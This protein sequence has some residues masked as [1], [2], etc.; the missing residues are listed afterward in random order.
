MRSQDGSPQRAA[1][2]RTGKNNIGL[3][4]QT[5]RAQGTL[6]PD[7]RLHRVIAGGRHRCSE[8]RLEWFRCDVFA[9]AT[10]HLPRAANR[11]VSRSK[12]SEG[13]DANRNGFTLPV[14]HCPEAGQIIEFPGR[15]ERIRTS[16]PCVPNTVLYQAELHS[17]RAAPYSGGVRPLQGGKDIR[18][19]IAF[20]GRLAGWW[21]GGAARCTAEGAV[22]PQCADSLY[23]R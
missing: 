1:G 22:S 23:V 3:P 2:C 17:D 10:R 5:T 4:G 18:S 20:G 16:G 15:S 6:N 19:G 9:S 12:A 21:V 7:C 11:S 8:G 13:E 14:G